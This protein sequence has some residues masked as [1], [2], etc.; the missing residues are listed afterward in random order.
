VISVEIA[1]IVFACVFGGALLGMFLSIHIPERHLSEGARDV[2]K[3]GMGLI[4]TMTALVLGLVVATAKSSYDAH[5]EAV[6]HTAAKI[7]LLDRVLANYGPETKE[8]RDLLRRA[9]AYRLKVIW[10]EGRIQRARLDV[11]E[12]VP[13]DRGVELGILQLSPQSDVQRWLRSEAL[14]INT[15]IIETR[16]LVLGG[17]VSSVP[18]PFLVVVVF[19]LAIIFGIFGLLAPRNPTVVVVLLVCAFSVASSIFLILE[20]NRPF[21]GLMRISSTPLHYALSQLGR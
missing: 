9:I 16:W 7:L 21:E 3:L 1:L 15:D 17:G 18:T 10:P 4:A 11:P 14:Q 20:M 2:I 13:M 6:K 12:T 5:D 8:T 19:W